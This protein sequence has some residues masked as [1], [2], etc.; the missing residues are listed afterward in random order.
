MEKRIKLQPGD[1][2]PPEEN[3]AALGALENDC[4][5]RKA[6]PFLEYARGREGKMK[7]GVEKCSS[8][9]YHTYVWVLAWEKNL[10]LGIGRNAHLLSFRCWLFSLC[11]HPVLFDFY[12]S[13]LSV[14]PCSAPPN[15]R[16]C[17]DLSANKNDAS[18]DADTLGGCLHNIFHL[19][20]LRQLESA[21]DCLLYRVACVWVGR[22]KGETPAGGVAHDGVSG[23][24]QIFG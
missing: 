17:T 9:R 24:F 3:R 13:S 22:K 21:A 20:C 6:A 2:Q 23:T 12:P 10:L 11:R 16:I 5:K 8:W 4:C 19:K 7:T 15:I 18:E 1:M 14:S